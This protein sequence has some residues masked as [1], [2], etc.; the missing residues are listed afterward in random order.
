MIARIFRPVFTARRSMLVLGVVAVGL[1]FPTGA[2]ATLF[3]LNTRLVTK[4]HGFKFHLHVFNTTTGYGGRNGTTF[5]AFFSR[6]RGHVTQT[7]AYTFSTKVRLTGK[8]K[9][10]SGQIKGT[11]ADGR[12]SI[13]MTFHGT[14]KP[15]KASGG[16]GGPGGKKRT[17]TLRG[18]LTLK[19][20]KL[21]TV[22]L[23]SAGATLSTASSMCNP[24]SP[25]PTKGYLLEAYRGNTYLCDSKPKSTGPAREVIRTTKNGGSA[26]GGGYGWSFAYTYASWNEPT[27]DYTLNTSN[28]SSAKVKGASGI[29][30]NATYSGK[31]SKHHSTGKMTGNL[32]VHMVVLGTV[33]PFASAKTLSADQRHP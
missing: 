15:S 24:P 31:K 9:S 6:T 2:M 30:G 7:A 23:K 18:S 29:H 14:G 17:G 27:S 26:P 20:D 11:F 19:A 1:A 8:M 5:T 4:S 25:C 22:R 16:C 33:S 28:L 32:S 3:T 10:G 12:G 13:N 21:G